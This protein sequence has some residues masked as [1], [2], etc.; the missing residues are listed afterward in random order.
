MR[1]SIWLVVSGLALIIACAE[2]RPPSGGPPDKTPPTFVSSFPVSGEVG[3]SGEPKIKIRFS[4]TVQ[5]GTGPQVFI[6]P[7]PSGKP[8]VKWHGSELSITLPD[9]LAPNQTYVIQV[10]AATADL[11]GN[12]LDSAVIV[13]FSTGATID[14][15]TISGEVTQNGSAASGATVAL[16]AVSSDT[17]TLVYDSANAD[18][19]TVTNHKGAFDFRYLPNRH[20]RLIAFSDKNRNEQFNPKTEPYGLPDRPIQVGDSLELSHVTLDMAAVDTA[21]PQVLSALYTQ[22]KVVKIRLSKEI[23][24]AYLNAHADSVVLVDSATQSISSQL[25]AFAEKGDSSSSNLTMQFGDLTEGVYEL[26]LRYDSLLPAMTAPR[27]QVKLGKDKESPSA[28]SW[29]PGDKPLF[30]PAIKVG[31]T[32]SEPIDSLS[33]APGALVLTENDKDTV[34][35]TTNWSDPFHLN[36]I[37][38]KLKPGAKYR[39]DLFGG[40]IAD[41][42]GNLVSDS[43]KSYRFATLSEDS[44]GTVTG[45]IEVTIPGR[46]TDPVVLLLQDLKRKAKYRWSAASREF[47][48]DVPAGKYL[49]SGFVDSDRDGVRSAGTLSPFRPSES[50]A[51]HPDTISVRARFETT[52]IEFRLK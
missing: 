27:L 11:R 51:A 47:R 45:T 32:F 21:Q 34:A 17:A 29:R 24:L 19:M 9:D 13:A 4:E 3:V 28:V 25:R 18:Y 48:F 7:K 6:S 16:F 1:G 42:A 2:V 35:V 14:S 10:S 49:L 38:E 37:P 30:V 50:S 36:V 15:G 41:R 44:L 39:L 26:R 46:E 22:S 23:P 43:M 52:G 31:L 40:G 20:F 12:K 8:K 33:P 5:A